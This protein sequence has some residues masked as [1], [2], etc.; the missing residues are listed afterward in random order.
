VAAWL[1]ACCIPVH[2]EDSKPPDHIQTPAAQQ[3]VTTAKD[4]K[5]TITNGSDAAC[6]TKPDGP[7]MRPDTGEAASSAEKGDQERMSRASD[8]SS[9][10]E[11]LTLQA[12]S[13]EDWTKDQIHLS[14]ETTLGE[15]SRRDKSDDLKPGSELKCTPHEAA[16]KTELV[17]PN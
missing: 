5:A 3:R 9:A 8:K 6:T 1:F 14:T 4:G 10:R 7:V 11:S 2:A 13:Q 16:P 15:E 17:T 12:P